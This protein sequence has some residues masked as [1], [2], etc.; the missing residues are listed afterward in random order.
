MSQKLSVL[1]FQANEAFVSKEKDAGGDT[2]VL[3]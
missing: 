1:I 3:E 2:E